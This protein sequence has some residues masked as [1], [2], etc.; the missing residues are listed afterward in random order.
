MKT[1]EISDL[2]YL[3]ERFAYGGASKGITF[4]TL[5]D[6]CE[7][8]LEWM[9]SPKELAHELFRYR[10]LDKINTAKNFDK[11]ILQESFI[12]LFELTNYIKEYSGIGNEEYHNAFVSSLEKKFREVQMKFDERGVN[13]MQEIIVVNQEFS[14]LVK[15]VDGESVEQS[16]KEEVR[17]HFKGLTNSYGSFIV[18]MN[19]K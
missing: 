14:D 8:A 4:Q 13:L 19:G 11:K 17:H 15:E 3:K 9:L 18:S 7:K 1:L 16:I 10:L 5:I 6:A 12:D 2:K